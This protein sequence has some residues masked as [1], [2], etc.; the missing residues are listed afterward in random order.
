MDLLQ[1]C[2]NVGIAGVADLG[3][4]PNTSGFAPSVSHCKWANYSDD[5]AKWPQ[6]S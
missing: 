3:A 6:Y 5:L 2:A 4:E 1:T